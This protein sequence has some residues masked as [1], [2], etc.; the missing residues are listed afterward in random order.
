M[1]M[2]KRI[3]YGFCGWTL[4]TGSI[5]AANSAKSVATSAHQP[6]MQSIVE[7]FTADIRSLGR[8]YAV[9]I[10][11]LRIARFEKFYEDT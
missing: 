8:A 6:Q 10:S 5:Y 4:A 7:Q 2:L 1:W 11:P 3:L 9:D